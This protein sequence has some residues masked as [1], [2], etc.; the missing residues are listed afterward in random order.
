MNTDEH[1]LNLDRITWRIIGCVFRVSNTLGCGFLEKVYENAL[2]IELRRAGLR[3]EQQ[4]AMSVV[5][6]GI[7]IGEFAADLL[8]E[9]QVIV[10]LKAVRALDDAHFSQCMNY[11]R[12]CGL[13]LCLLVNFG[14]PR[15]Q[16]KRVVP[17]F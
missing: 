2:T 13:K 4:H 8:V 10:E 11:L 14:R 1:R 7:S 12:A 15:V 17:H 3:L 9:N 16:I 6:D 5:Y